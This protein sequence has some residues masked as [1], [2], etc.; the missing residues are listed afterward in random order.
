MGKVPLE[1]LG[2]KA[3]FSLVNRSWRPFL[4][5][6]IRHRR[7]FSNRLCPMVVSPKAWAQSQFSAV[8]EV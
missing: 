7:L 4:Q 8:A 2:N 3:T 1:L 6:A 5:H